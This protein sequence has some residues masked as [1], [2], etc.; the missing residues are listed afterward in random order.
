MGAWI[1]NRYFFIWDHFA[2]IFFNLDLVDSQND[3]KTLISTHLKLI[4]LKTQKSKTSS[5]LHEKNGFFE[6]DLSTSVATFSS[7]ELASKN[8]SKYT[9]KTLV[10]KVNGRYIS[11]CT[12]VKI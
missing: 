7:P 4:K 6:F 8:K 11:Y 5:D 2:N 1:N 12:K 10:F 3:S 9:V